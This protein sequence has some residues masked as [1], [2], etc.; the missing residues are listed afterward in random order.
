VAV[1]RRALWVLI[2][3]RDFCL[4]ML[5]KWEHFIFF[6]EKSPSLFL[7]VSEDLS[8]LRRDPLYADA[9]R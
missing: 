3:R 2:S 6:S 1:C 7:K 9:L 4:G 8:P 5:L